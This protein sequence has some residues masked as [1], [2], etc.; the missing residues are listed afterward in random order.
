MKA[1]NEELLQDFL[2]INVHPQLIFVKVKILRV[3]EIY[4]MLI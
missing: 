1:C 4:S 2:Y 3:R